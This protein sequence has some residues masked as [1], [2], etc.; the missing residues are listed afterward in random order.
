[1]SNGY[2]CPR[3][4]ADLA[5]CAAEHVVE[6]WE[7]GPE[8]LLTGLPGGELEPTAVDRAAEV[9]ACALAGSKH[10][11]GRWWPSAPIRRG[12]TAFGITDETVIDVALDLL[13][14]QVQ[15]HGANGTRWRLERN[16]DLPRPA[17]ERI[18]ECRCGQ[19]SHEWRL[20]TGGPWTCALCHPPLRGLEVQSR[21]APGGEP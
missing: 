13:K 17:I 4:R 10:V 15:K 19:R 3:S 14:V 7:V 5:W 8:E 2:A 16:P 6:L 1:M 21:T 20:A 18:A 11:L 9:I 12:L